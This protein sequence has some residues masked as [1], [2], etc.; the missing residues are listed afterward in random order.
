MPKDSSVWAC[1][2]SHLK[3]KASSRQLYNGQ[4]DHSS[5]LE[6]GDG[7]PSPDGTCWYHLALHGH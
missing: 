2:H 5:Y 6:V 4:D 7:S 3:D 1:S